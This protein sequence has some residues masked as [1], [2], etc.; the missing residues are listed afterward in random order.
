MT[1]IWRNVGRRATE[2]N[3]DDEEATDRIGRDREKTCVAGDVRKAHTV[4]DGNRSRVSATWIVNVKRIV[5]SDCLFGI[6]DK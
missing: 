6:E 3:D 5:D 2:E 4:D 1:P